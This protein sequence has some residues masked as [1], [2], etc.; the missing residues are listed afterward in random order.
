MPDIFLISTC[1]LDLFLDKY[2]KL[3]LRDVYFPYTLRDSCFKVDVRNFLEDIKNY[4]R[5][6]MK[7]AR[8]F[9]LKE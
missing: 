8:I 1:T 3:S 2:M 6:F 4:I 7:F 9:V 5:F